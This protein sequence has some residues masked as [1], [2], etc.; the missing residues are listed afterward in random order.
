[1]LDKESIDR[2][3]KIAA[4]EAT[5]EL[6]GDNVEKLPLG[7]ALGLFVDIHEVVLLAACGHLDEAREKQERRHW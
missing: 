5:L 4:I 6:M 2:N 1:M 7:V 3:V